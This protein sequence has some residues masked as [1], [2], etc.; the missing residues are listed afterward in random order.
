MATR[1]IFRNTLVIAIALCVVM[2]P[3]AAMS[4]CGSQ[5]GTHI[6]TSAA[7]SA[8]TDQGCCTSEKKD[9]EQPVEPEDEGCCQTCQYCS[10]LHAQLADVV[11][12]WLLAGTANGLAISWIQM[13][14]PA[15]AVDDMLRPPLC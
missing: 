6:K 15:A 2:A 8:S 12:R 1:S 3:A 11:T 10:T 13:S 4:V 5:C 14:S 9:C 7:D